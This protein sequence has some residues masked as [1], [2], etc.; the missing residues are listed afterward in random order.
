MRY[1]ESRRVAESGLAL[2]IPLYT[3]FRTRGHP[4]VGTTLDYYESRGLKVVSGR[5][6]GILGEC[7]AGAKVARALAVEP[8]GHVVSSPESVF[9]LAGVYPLRMHVVGVLAPSGTPDDDAIFVDIRTAWV[10]EGLAH[11]H[12]DMSRPEA[13]PGVLRRAENVVIANASVLQYNEITAE[14]VDSFHFHGDPDGFPITAVI[15]VP[16]D[17]KSSAL[18]QG[19]Y[20]GQDEAVQIVQ[21]L[22]VMEEL[23]ATIL[24]VQQYVIAAIVIVALSTLATVALVFLLSIRLRRREIETMTK[25][26]APRRVVLSVLVSEIAAVLLAGLVLASGLTALTGWLGAAAMQA[27]LLQQ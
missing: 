16:H 27:F 26:G 4:I 21:P 7:V 20:L 12:Q 25:L 6:Q 14:N 10:I 2:A 8:G 24:T 5:S 9:D 17:E 11:G 19:R 22:G 18:L 13:A 23:L 3:R 1:G 15:A